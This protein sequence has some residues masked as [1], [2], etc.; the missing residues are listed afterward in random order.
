LTA[1]IFREIADAFRNVQRKQQELG[2]YLDVTVGVNGVT[3]YLGRW[4]ERP[5]GENRLSCTMDEGLLRRV[6][7]REVHWNDLELGGWIEFDRRGPYM[8]D[9]HTLMCFFHLPRE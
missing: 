8:P 6:L 7:H 5:S 2:C 9:L 3:A 4:G 1:P